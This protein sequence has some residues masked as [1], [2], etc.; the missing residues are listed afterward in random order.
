MQEMMAGYR[1]EL[2]TFIVNIIL[3][4]VNMNDVKHGCEPRLSWVFTTLYACISLSTSAEC[5]LDTRKR[6]KA[7]PSTDLSF[8]LCQIQIRNYAAVTGFQG[9]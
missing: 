7:V 9:K 5:D 6:A 8:K 4:F 3:V 1:L 2:N